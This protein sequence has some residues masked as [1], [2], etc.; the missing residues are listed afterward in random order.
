MV[1]CS[2]PLNGVVTAFT[3][4]DM[5]AVVPSALTSRKTAEPWKPALHATDVDQ[6]G[7]VLVGPVAGFSVTAPGSVP[8]VPAKAAPAEPARMPPDSTTTATARP[9]RPV[10][11]DFS[12]GDSI[13]Y[14]FP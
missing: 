4:G 12:L 1:A 10:A 3:A 11:S 8:T 6:V 9:N 5:E 13:R 14:T 7:L 2:V